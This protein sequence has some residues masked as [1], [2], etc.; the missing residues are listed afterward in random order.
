ME[1]GICAPLAQGVPKAVFPRDLIFA[2]SLRIVRTA[3]SP[4]R[5]GAFTCSH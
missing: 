2:F 3:S 4:S 1:V 5:M